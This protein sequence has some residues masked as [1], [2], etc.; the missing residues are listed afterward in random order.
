MQ[1]SDPLPDLMSGSETGKAPLGMINLG[2]SHT[3]DSLKATIK[4]RE[5]M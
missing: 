4:G 1:I 3:H 2:D 5:R